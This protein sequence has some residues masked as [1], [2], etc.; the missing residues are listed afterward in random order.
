MSRERLWPDECCA[1]IRGDCQP[2]IP[3]RNE[4]SVGDHEERQRL[5]SR[6]AGG[7]RADIVRKSRTCR[8]TGVPPRR[9]AKGLL[10]ARRSR[11]RQEGEMVLP[12]AICLDTKRAGN[13]RHPVIACGFGRAHQDMRRNCHAD[14]NGTARCRSHFPGGSGGRDRNCD[15]RQALHHARAGFHGHLSSSQTADRRILFHFRLLKGP[16]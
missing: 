1:A 5:P 10:L 8:R 11:L 3:K 7:L 9:C 14:R 4:I 2:I 15:R 16:N 6:A 13:A 12:N